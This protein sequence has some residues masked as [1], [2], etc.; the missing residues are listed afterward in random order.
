[1]LQPRGR[2]ISSSAAS[3][4]RPLHRPYPDPQRARLAAL[5]EEEATQRRWYWCLILSSATSLVL[6]MLELLLSV[7]LL[8]DET[9]SNLNVFVLQLLVYVLIG[10]AL[11]G[12]VI[13]V[14]GLWVVAFL[15]EA[16]TLLGLPPPPQPMVPQRKARKETVGSDEENAGPLLT[17]AALSPSSIA[18]TVPAS[19][20]D[21]SILAA[22]DDGDEHDSTQGL[23]AAL[24]DPD[25]SPL[26]ALSPVS[27]HVQQ[28]QVS[29]APTLGRS[30]NNEATSSVINSAS[31]G[32]RP[33][34]PNAAYA[35]SSLPD[36]ILSAYLN[37]SVLL[38]ILYFGFAVLLLAQRTQVA[39]YIHATAMTYGIVPARH[40]H[41]PHH[42]YGVTPGP[43]D[44]GDPEQAALA[45]R[46]QLAAYL[47]V[48]GV[49]AI[50]SSKLMSVGTIA[51]WQIQ[52]RRPFTQQAYLLSH[53]TTGFFGCVLISIRVYILHHQTFVPVHTGEIDWLGVVGSLVV[54]AS[55]AGVAK[56]YAWTPRVVPMMRLVHMTAMGL[57]TF[58]LLLLSAALW[59]RTKQGRFYGAHAEAETESSPLHAIDVNESLWD[60]ELTAQ[61]KIA[62]LSIT[63][64]VTALY[65]FVSAV[66]A[67]Q[68]DDCMLTQK[69]PTD[70]MSLLG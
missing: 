16:H 53:L 54:M 44:L 62:L 11:C 49:C 46:T 31:T 1:M 60:L 18:G 45:L 50:F 17:D 26:P 57:L 37:H 58:I 51:A 64:L 34:S 7:H 4:I 20:N 23:R 61:L 42:N 6:C 14:L 32:S 8:L 63:V 41:G 28:V 30:L 69:P 9:W 15:V 33:T 27:V 2:P 66:L 24:R 70:P 65:T 59:T 29:Q 5:T 55:F 39:E 12:L 48:M 35:N 3:P 47:A 43:D 68:L 13:A 10:L 19:S 25:A 21:E 56:F 52:R 36:T 38:L 67:R 22:T 40:A